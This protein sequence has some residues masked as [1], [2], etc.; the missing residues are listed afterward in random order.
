MA[1]FRYFE[2][3]KEAKDSVSMHVAKDSVMTRVWALSG[4]LRDRNG[5]I[6]WPPST[7]RIKISPGNRQQLSR[8]SRGERTERTRL[9]FTENHFASP[10]VDMT[11]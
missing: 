1:I 7:T 2:V 4:E 9:F 3:L 5:R 10:P 6:S 11:F 8:R